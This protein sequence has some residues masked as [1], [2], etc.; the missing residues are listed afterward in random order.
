ME[1]GEDP[2]G[3]LGALWHVQ[4]P[5]ELCLTWLCPVFI[6]IV[7][8]IDNERGVSQVAQVVRLYQLL[9]HHCMSSVIDS[10]SDC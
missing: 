3:H 6:V 8:S 1:D 4:H 10:V 9:L 7:Q 5:S 2:E